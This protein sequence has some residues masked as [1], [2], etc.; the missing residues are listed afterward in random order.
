[1]TTFEV[2]ED[3]AQD[4][5]L[6][7]ELLR[8]GGP[9][10]RTRMP[11]GLDCYIVT[12]FAQARALLA[13]PR[14]HKNSARARELFEAKLPSGQATQAG[15]GADLGFHMLNS[16]P[17]DHTRLRKLVNKAFTARTIARLRPRVEEITSELLDALAGQERADLLPAFAAPLPITVIC[18]L[19]GVRAQ[20][21]TEFAAWSKTL[22]SASQPEE[23]QAAG[24]NMFG[25]LTDLIAQKRAEP[26]EDLLSDLVHATDDGDSLSEPELVSMAFLLLVAG[27]ET[28]VNLIA[29]GVLA[30][31]REPAQLARLRAEPELL[32]NAVEE[33][34]RFD[35]PIHLATL[36]FTAEPVE[37]GGVTI[38]EGE[39]VLVSLLGA[40]RDA[41]RYPEPDR[42]DITRAAGG[43]LAFG[44]GIHYCVGAPLARLEAEIALGGLIARFPELALD[45]KPDE[46][47]Y[48]PSSLVHGLEALPVRL[49]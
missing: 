6:F 21:R 14:L 15:V 28:T 10:R 25:Y 9:V 39:F 44:H 43:H 3:F 30:L 32:P 12:D 33:L 46:L 7:A 35:G 41:E 26:A 5:H 40:N 22:L 27:H 18:E 29:N 48:R 11:R 1:M 13:D 17:P 31:L 36:R 38:P 42:L 20:D 16:D 2:A 45:A 8:A 19:L 37:V 47:V 34:L 4:A 49:K 24:Q 23:M